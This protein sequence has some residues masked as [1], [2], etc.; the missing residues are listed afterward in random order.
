MKILLIMSCSMCP[1][2]AQFNLE[3]T[4]Y[5][6]SE[7]NKIIKDKKMP[8]ECPLDNAIEKIKEILKDYKQ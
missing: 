8:N 3:G 5:Y 7:I 4:E 6:C 1:Y 2:G